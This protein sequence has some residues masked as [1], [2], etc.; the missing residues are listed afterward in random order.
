MTPKKLLKETIIQLVTTLPVVSK[1]EGHM[2]N[3]IR[4]KIVSIANGSKISEKQEVLDWTKV[5]DEV[6]IKSVKPILQELLELET[7]DES[8]LD[9]SHE[10]IIEK[11]KEIVKQSKLDE[12]LK[13][14]II[15]WI[16]KYPKEDNKIKTI[17]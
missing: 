7:T 11:I 12:E 6:Q 5:I 14:S 16:I 2:K 3:P 4:D 10:Q 8:V 9:L 17:I 13:S 1:V 15:D